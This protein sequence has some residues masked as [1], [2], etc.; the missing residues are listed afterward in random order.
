MQ[1]VDQ[2]YKDLVNT[3]IDEGRMDTGDVR[4]HYA[5]GAPSYTKKNFKLEC[6]V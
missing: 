5:D 2:I 6:C 3:I 4:A 1:Q